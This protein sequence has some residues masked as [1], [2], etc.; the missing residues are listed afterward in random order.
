LQLAAWSSTD[1][2]DDGDVHQ[3]YVHGLVVHL[4]HHVICAHGSNRSSSGP[5]LERGDPNEFFPILG[6]KQTIADRA[7]PSQRYGGRFLFGFEYFGKLNP[8]AT[9]NLD[10]IGVSERIHRYL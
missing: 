10:E 4:Q 9:G 8:E 1:G 6:I 7:S 3:A 5:T 2:F